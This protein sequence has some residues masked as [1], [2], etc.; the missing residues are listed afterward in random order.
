[1]TQILR[2]P[3]TYGPKEK[4]VARVQQDPTLSRPFGAL[5]P[6]LAFEMTDLMYD[7]ERKLNTV[8]MIPSPNTN[9]NLA[10]YVYNPVPYNLNFNLYIMVKNAEDG[11]KILEQILPFFTP[12]WT[13]TVRMIDQP[14]IDLD[15][16]C[17]LNSVSS[18]DTW[19]GGF[20]ERRYL[21]WTLN[22][23]MKGNLYGPIKKDKIIKVAKTNLSFDNYTETDLESNYENRT[24]HATVTVKPGLDANGNPTSDA[25]TSLPY[26]DI[27]WTDDFGFVIDE[28]V[29]PN[30]K[31]VE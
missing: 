29:Y 12:E 7:G 17:V 9:K 25:N 31:I 16:P 3:I 6:R 20:E 4:V 18:Q 5:L 11:T 13:T 23:T 21:V 14:P 19:D 24:I 1:M 8:G 22:F 30:G 27:S 10:D 28:E 15:V 2:V 26:S